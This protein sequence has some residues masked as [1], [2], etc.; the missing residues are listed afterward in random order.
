MSEASVANAACSMSFQLSIARDAYFARPDCYESVFRRLVHGCFERL[1]ASS[2]NVSY[3]S[4]QF[5]PVYVV[6]SPRLVRRRAAILKQLSDAGSMDVTLVRCFEIA[7]IRSLRPS[8]RACV[9]PFYAQTSFSRPNGMANGTLGLALKHKAAIWDAYQ[10]RLPAALVL[11]DDA[12]FAPHEF[13]PQI[14]NF[15]VPADA[16]IFWLGSYAERPDNRLPQGTNC[17]ARPKY[18]AWFYTSYIK[19][20]LGTLDSQQRVD[21]PPLRALHHPVHSPEAQRETAP[22]VYRRRNG[23]FPHIIGALAYIVFGRAMSALA[24]QPVVAETDIALS[25]L[26][27]SPKCLGPSAPHCAFCAPSSQYGPEWWVVKADR[28][29]FGQGS[30]TL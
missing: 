28:K 26:S 22:K 19:Y 16:D 24:H 13:W 6:H 14:A 21:V 18:C 27:P 3:V 2:L 8:Q 7:S 10:R 29:R 4:A 15:R 11:E 25:L 9:H 12:L 23:S 20:S 17:T 5:L 1:A 30:H